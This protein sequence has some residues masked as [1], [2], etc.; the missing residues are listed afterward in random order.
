MSAALRVLSSFLASVQ[1]T[2][3]P[4]AQRYGVPIGGAM[5]ALALQAANR[6]VG[7]PADAAGLEITAG[8]TAVELLR[9]LLL[10]V[11]GADLGAELDGA[12]LPLW[13]AVYARKGA[14]LRFHRRRERWGARAY[15]A[16]AGGVEAPVLLGSRGTNV[17]GGFGGP[18]GRP[19]RPGDIIDAPELPGDPLR[20]AGSGWPTAARPHY[21]PEPV[22]RA[23]TGPHAQGFVGGAAALECDIF[24]VSDDISR[25]G[26]RLRGQA[27]RYDGPPVDSLGVVPGALQ[28]PPNGQPILLMAEAQTVGGYPIAAVVI[29]PDLPLAAQL[30]PHDTL[31]FRLIER[32]EALDARREL[33]RWL[34]AEPQHDSATEALAQ[35]G[36]PG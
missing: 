22:L 14:L 25:I 18:A 7:N 11:A 5:D 3:R 27:L 9:P 12:A 30:L 24:S 29:G 28:V 35:A 19:L 26:Y 31:R 1:D 21:R 20:L 10:A 4:G 23:I 34:A 13:R 16:L 6:L 33:A 2:G 17:A 36:W 8:A 15:L 32:A